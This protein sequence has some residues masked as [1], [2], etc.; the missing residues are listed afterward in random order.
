MKTKMKGVVTI[1]PKTSVIREFDMPQMDNDSVMI[2]LKYCGVCHSEHYDWAHTQQPTG[3]GHE[4]MGIIVEVGKNVKGYNVGDRVSG[5]WGS[6]LP[7]AGA[8]VEYQV[9][10]V[11]ESTI[12][13]LP[14]DIRDED[15]IVEPL[16]CMFS[17][18]SKVK[19]TMPGTHICVVGCGYM[20]CGAISL[21]K[22]RGF[23]VVAVDIR[24]SSRQDA[25]KYG[26]AEAY[27]PEE[28]IEKF[29]TNAKMENPLEA[30]FEVV[31]EWGESNESLD[32]AIRLTKMCGLLCVGAYHT[33]PKREVDMQQLGVKAIV[34]HNTHPREAWLSKTGAESAVCM[35]ESGEWNY[36]DIP[37]MVYPMNQFDRAQE[38]METKYGRFMKSVISMEMEDG[39]P[40][41]AK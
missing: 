38:E 15:L 33:G 34:M 41:L 19:N 2:K 29:I 5:L 17:A 16:S 39:E 1:A 14:D 26:A 30:G 28:A 11:S 36:R 35:L 24:E 12:I 7:G 21:L 31:C 27:S 4:P 37:T 9:A 25:L 32:T 23:H 6:T 40:Y 13:K 10:K 22:L 20:G 8:M 18:V 3:F